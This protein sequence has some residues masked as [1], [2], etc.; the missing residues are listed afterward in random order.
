MVFATLVVNYLYSLAGRVKDDIQNPDFEDSFSDL[1]GLKTL[2]NY[3]IPSLAI[4]Y[5]IYLWVNELGW[6]AH[7]MDWIHLLTRWF[8]II[9]GIAWIGASFYFIFLENALNRTEGL[10]NELA[11]NLWAVHG[12][13]F[14]YLEKLKTAPGILPKTL[15]WFKY[16]AYFTWISGVTLLFLVYYFNAGAYM[17]DPSVSNISPEGAIA[18]GLGSLILGWLIYDG[19]CRTPLLQQKKTFA[20]VGFGII[21]VFTFGLSHILSGRAAFMHVGALLGTIMAGNVFFS[22]IPSQKALVNAAKMGKPVNAELGKIAG[23]RSLHNNYMTFPVLFVMMSNHF[24]VTFGGKWNWV[25]MAFIILGSVAVRHFINLHEKGVFLKWMLPIAACIVIGLVIFTAPKS[26]KTKMEPGEKIAFSDVMPI[27]KERCQ[28]C[29]SSHPTDDV[30]TTAPSG[31]LFET[32]DQIANRKDKI[33]NRVVETK[34]M[35]QGNKTKMTDEERELIANW[36]E[37]GAPN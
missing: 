16:E 15:H 5:G 20:L 25:V 9:I 37:S 24:P 23:L 28:S 3:G 26:R 12:G 6:N 34:S 18:V 31:V 10:R 7:V 35:P 29:H 33:M 36:I 30:F 32:Y 11:G 19:L 22:I 2:L 27:F 14:Y 13:G 4:G 21:L 8:H 17:I 1:S